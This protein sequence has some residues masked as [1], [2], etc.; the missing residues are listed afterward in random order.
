MFEV[1]DSVAPI[2]LSLISFTTVGCSD[3]QESNSHSRAEPQE[4]AAIERTAASSK[5]TEAP[6]TPL[7]KDDY[8]PRKDEFR[9]LLPAAISA[10][11]ALLELHNNLEKAQADDSLPAPDARVELEKFLELYRPFASQFEAHDVRLF[12]GSRRG[13]NIRL[14]ISEDARALQNATTTNNV[15]DIGAAI[16]KLIRGLRLFVE[17]TTGKYG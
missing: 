2:V 5:V 3:H 9:K 6:L 7:V 8:F 15:S 12:H 1:R 13:E 16:D 17:C 4:S 14:T 11:N 10:H